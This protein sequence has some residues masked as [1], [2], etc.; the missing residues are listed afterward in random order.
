MGFIAA[1]LL[2]FATVS[3]Y[4]SYFNTAVNF[5]RSYTHDEPFASFLKSSLQLIKN[6]EAGIVKRLLIYVIVISEWV[7]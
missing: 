5:V 1:D 7:I 3:R 4:Y 6:L 2:F